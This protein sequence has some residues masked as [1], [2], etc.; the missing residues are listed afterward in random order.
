MQSLLSYCFCADVFIA[1]FTLV[2]CYNA[3]VLFALSIFVALLFCYFMLLC[4]VIVFIVLLSCHCRVSAVGVLI[5]SFRSI[6]S[7]SV[8]GNICASCKF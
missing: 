3:I 1:S 7:I 5:Q 8:S 6:F 2:C 4:C